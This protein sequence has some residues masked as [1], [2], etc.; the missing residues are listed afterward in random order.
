[1]K[2]LGIGLEKAM[3]RAAYVCASL[4]IVS[5]MVTGIPITVHA[6]GGDNY[7]EPWRSAPKDTYIDNWGYYSRNCTSWVAWALYDRNSFNMH[8]AIGNASNW[9]NW[10]QS[11][12]YAVNM[13]PRV[14]SVAWWTSNHVAWVKSVNSNNTVTIEE[15]NYGYTGNY[16]IRD[17]S[18]GSVSGYIHFKDIVGAV[19]ISDGTYIKKS[20]NATVYRVVGG[21][22]IKVP[23]WS[24]VG[25]SKPVTVVTQ[26]QFDGL[27][28][29]PVDGTYIKEH[30][31]N[32]TVYSV[33]G[34][35]PIP[36]PSWS[37][38]GGSKPVIVVPSG[39]TSRSPFNAYPVD[40]TYIKEHGKA[41][42]YAMAGG[43][44][45][46]VPGWSSVG[47]S[48]RTIVIPNGSINYSMFR[49]Y[50]IDNTYIK[51]H[52]NNTVYVMAGGAPI[53]I[54][55]WSSI[56]GPKPVTLVP[57]NSLNTSL[58]HQYP[59]NGTYVKEYGNQT[60]YT[61]AGGFGAKVSS[62][63]AV[64]GE[65][66]FVIIPQNGLENSGRFVSYPLDGTRVRAFGSELVNLI[67]EGAAV[68]LPGGSSGQEP[69][70]IV[71]QWAID[72][73]ILQ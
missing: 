39:A 23:S 7:P 22:P 2:Q 51:E 43:A 44:P 52:G 33:V 34:G 42:V 29:Y 24:S 9:G 8:Q 60:I 59:V 26:Q 17:I 40:G 55:S 36:V 46:P 10:A 25:G 31:G 61:V 70:V 16:N 32:A 38:V 48:K 27:N 63:T 4:L 13:T 18:V 65:K 47:G 20:G 50:P 35:S 58:F 68:E 45:I 73:Q 19:G 66:P 71:D 69:S 41:T 6:G 15:Y 1:M 57:A 62:W 12:G 67:D 54:P 3:K 11:K 72:N 56:G 37:S 53:P 30:G 28:D 21:A 64:G 49:D 14:G 5:G